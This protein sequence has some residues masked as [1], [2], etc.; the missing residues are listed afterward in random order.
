MT[1]FENTNTQISVSQMISEAAYK[2]VLLV[3]RM[4]RSR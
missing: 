2:V 3:E 4:I 1:T